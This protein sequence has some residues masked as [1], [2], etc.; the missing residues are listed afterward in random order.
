MKIGEKKRQKV[1]KRLIYAMEV[2]TIMNNI[3][4]IYIREP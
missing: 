2:E 3:I 4:Y 1:N